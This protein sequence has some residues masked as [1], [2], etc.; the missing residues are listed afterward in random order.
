MLLSRAL[1]LRRRGGEEAGLGVAFVSA[2]A[3]VVVSSGTQNTLL[4]HEVA[5][6]FYL[7]AGLTVRAFYDRAPE[8]E[9]EP[10]AQ[11]IIV[12]PLQAQRLA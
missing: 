11:P 3:A 9:P 12:G 6:P 4:V 2:F 8:S 7:A 1:A 5:L 10:V